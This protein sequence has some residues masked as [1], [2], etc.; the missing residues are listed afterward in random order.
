[1]YT[2]KDG[3]FNVAKAVK[4][5]II[6]LVV[7]LTLVIF[8]PLR[9]VP[10]GTR[11]VLVQMGAIKGI[12]PEGPHLLW[13]WER[14][15]I[16]S[17]R[18]ETA[19]IDHASGS[20]SDQQKV[21]TDL[22][23]RYSV[24][25]D[26]VA[27]VYEQY[28]HS[29]DLSTFVETATQEVFKAV[30]ARYTAPDLIAK[31]SDVSVAIKEALSSKLQQYGA[32]VI[33]IDMR[34]FDWSKEYAEAINNKVTQEQKKLAAENKALTTQAEQKEQVFIAEATAKAVQAKA[35][36][37]A[38]SVKVTA[39][40][41]AY[42]T[43]ADAKAQAES[44]RIQNEALRQNKDVLELRRIQV[45]QTKADNWDGTLPTA[46]YASAPIPFLNIKE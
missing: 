35:D 28:S 4:H 39:D 25:P 16:F 27:F 13:P 5:G 15:D 46:I 34:N 2:T 30:T 33:N 41:A 3:E 37:D 9:I 18:A 38:Y 45:E 6:A 32:R 26:Q 29:G 24:L 1:M 12:V 44:L 11:G 19:T 21:D 17:I 8:N 42:S 20:T 22:T 10:V 36:G 23:V 14:I 43:L 7:L 40:A 31:R